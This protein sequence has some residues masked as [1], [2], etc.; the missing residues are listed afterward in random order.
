MSLACKRCKRWLDL[1]S[2]RENLQKIKSQ[3]TKLV[4]LKA[5][6]QLWQALRNEQAIGDEVVLM[7]AESRFKLSHDC[8]LTELFAF[9]AHKQTTIF[10]SGRLKARLSIAGK[11]FI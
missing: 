4:I 11:W 9:S 8:F 1:L 5:H 7:L 3:T 6:E 10:L 2:A